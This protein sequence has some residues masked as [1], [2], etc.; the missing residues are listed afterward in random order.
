MDAP[1]NAEEFLPD[2][3][4]TLWQR[5]AHAAMETEAW[6]REFEGTRDALAKCTVNQAEA[7]VLLSVAAFALPS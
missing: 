7:L 4:G 6:Q 1:R 2:P 5:V 3:H